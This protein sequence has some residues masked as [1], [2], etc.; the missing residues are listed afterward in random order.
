MARQGSLKEFQ[1]ALAQR[2][3]EAAQAEPSSRLGFEAGSGRYLLKLEDAGEVLPVP[4]LT[5][6]PLTRPWFLGVANVRGT[7][8]CVVD[9]AAFIGEAPTVLGADAR[10]I[11]LAERFGAQ[12]ALVVSRMLGL[13]SLRSLEPAQASPGAPWLGAAFAERAGDA[14]AHWREIELE[15]LAGDEQFLQVGV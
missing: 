12:A 2:L 4:E 14:G 7:L 11:L 13:K 3:R 9:F 8:V 1:E 5:P 10:L 15:A 6:V